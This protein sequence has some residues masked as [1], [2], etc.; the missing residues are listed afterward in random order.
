MPES[1]ILDNLILKIANNDAR[2]MED[3]YIRTQSSVYGFALS[4]LKQQ[5]LA[6]DIMQETYIRVYQSAGR[7]K[8]Q[9]KPMSW[10]LTIVKNL[11]YNTLG[12]KSAQE[13]SL[14][15]EW[16]GTAK[17]FTEASIDNLV[18]KAMLNTLTLEERQ[19]ITLNSVVGLKFKEIAQ[20]LD[21]PLSTTLSKNY[22]ALSK[23]KKRV[24][25]EAN[26][27]N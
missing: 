21:L 23:L 25:E 9:N 12:R 6:E 5:H 13:L 19:I 24:K 22:R 11:S 2:A 10:V 27:N 26:E 15:E 14:E 1:K 20:I 4:I 16:V 18:L 7:Y 3:F 17:D 8:S